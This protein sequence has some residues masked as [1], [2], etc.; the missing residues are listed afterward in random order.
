MGQASQGT[1]ASQMPETRSV[2]KRARVEDA[3]QIAARSRP[4]TRQRCAVVAAWKGRLAPENLCPEALEAKCCV[5]NSGEAADEN[6]LA[7]CDRCDR[8]FHQLCHSPPVDFFGNPDDQWFCAE[9]TEE[10]IKQRG[11]SFT[12]GDFAWVRAP[13]ESQPWPSRVLRIDFSSL[14]DPK[15]YWVQFFDT[16][17]SQG[18]WVGE[19]QVTAWQDGP[20]F[21][22]VRDARRKLAVRLAEGD[23]AVPISSNVEQAPVKPVRLG[24]VN[25]SRSKGDGG[26]ASEEYAPQKRSRRNSTAPS[27]A[28]VGESQA[29]LQRMEEMSSQLE[30]AKKRQE[31]LEKE[32]EEV[33]SGAVASQA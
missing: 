13:V 5:C 16:G 27:S 12:V 10:L 19:A 32:M 24:R 21:D 18:A 31:A 3:S 17:A 33:R 14:A 7:L 26:Q 2:A 30:E 6:D 8:G 28:A 25:G 20:S 4:A 11:L 15:P 22:D 9:C 29:V 23:G 1:Q